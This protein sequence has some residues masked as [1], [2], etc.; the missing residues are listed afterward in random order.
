MS[1]TANDRATLRMCV[2]VAGFLDVP[3]FPDAE[4]IRANARRYERPIRRDE[5]QW[6]AERL[7]PEIHELEALLGWDCSGWLEPPAFDGT[8]PANED[9][10]VAR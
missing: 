7:A 10:G 5:W 6:L 8:Q 4:P 2:S 3:P 1:G 9:A